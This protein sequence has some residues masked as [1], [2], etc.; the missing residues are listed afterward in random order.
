MKPELR[1]AEIREIVRRALD[2]DLAGGDAASEATI[3]PSLRASGRVVAKTEGVVCGLEVA[4]EVF[5]Q[6]GGTAFVPAARDGARMRRGQALARVSGRARSILAA[7][8]TALNF[9]QQLSG[10]ATLT[11]AFVERVRGT[12]ARIL[13]TRKT[14]PGLRA[15]QKYAV[16]CGGGANHRRSLGDAA[17]IKD[18]HLR[19][20]GDPEAIR[21]M[22]L[23]LRLRRGPDFPIEI[24]AQSA[25]EAL[26]FSTF[27]VDVVMLDNLPVATMR[28]LV[29]AMRKLNPGLTIEASGGVTLD[30]VRSI[31]RTGVDRIS[32]GALTH[33]ARSVDLSLEL[34]WGR[35]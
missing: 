30:T 12:R 10:V 15:L 32:V 4:R 1:A 27:P 11:R 28:K 24:E 3:P 13:D 20:V 14:V 21:E 5:R 34:R 17:L 7:E 19:A 2:E 8:R 33:S 23:A 6:A 18:N 29:P 25:E 26:L 31:A 9:L 35:P 16:R 22:V